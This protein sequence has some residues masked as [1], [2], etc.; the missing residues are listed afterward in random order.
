[1]MEI[2]SLASR[3]TRLGE[4]E[5]W[6]TKKYMECE[7]QIRSINHKMNVA[8][9]NDVQSVQE[10]VKFGE[11]KQAFAQEQDAWKALIDMRN[12]LK[13]PEKLNPVERNKMEFAKESDNNLKEPEKTNPVER[14]KMEVAKE[15][16]NKLKLRNNE[17]KQETQLEF[18]EDQRRRK[19]ELDNDDQNHTILMKKHEFYERMP[20]LGN[21][22]TAAELLLEITERIA[23]ERNRSANRVGGVLARPQ[24]IKTLVTTSKNRVT[25]SKNRVMTSKNPVTTILSTSKTFKLSLISLLNP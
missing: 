12:S 13:E 11:E 6:E 2:K 20:Q 23:A 17:Q 21:H 7:E 19:L 18:E 16:D 8:E 4:L 24:C 10:Q 9:V 3:Q 1:M 5:Q 22:E 25:T 15:S 14:N